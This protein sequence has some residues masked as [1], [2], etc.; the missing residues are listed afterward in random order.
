M[1][2]FQFVLHA[3]GVLAFATFADPTTAKFIPVMVGLFYVG[4]ILFVLGYIV[5]PFARAL[6][7]GI[8]L[9]PTLYA[10]ATTI[11]QC[12]TRGFASF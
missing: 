1:Y 7:F 6:G 10:I 5:N 12:K 9:F 3:I 2:Y 8:T 11:M 4:R